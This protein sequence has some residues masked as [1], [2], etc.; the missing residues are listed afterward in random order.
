MAT[1]TC[2]LSCSIFASVKK[3][4]EIVVDI[5]L[6]SD[7]SN[8]NKNSSVRNGA[9]LA[10]KENSKKLKKN[11]IKIILNEYN[12]GK[13]VKKSLEVAREIT[14]SNSKAVIG[15]IWSSDALLASPIYNRNKIPLMVPGATADRLS[16]FNGYIHL[17]CNNNNKMAEKLAKFVKSKINPHKILSVVSQ[18]CAYCKNLNKVFQ[19]KLVGKINYKIFKILEGSIREKD[20]S[21]MIKTFKP[22]TIFL[23]NKARISAQLMKIAYEINPKISFVGADSWGVNPKVLNTILGDRPIIGYSFSQWHP[24]IKQKRSMKFQQL[25]VKT[26]GI[27][28]DDVAALTYDATQ[29]LIKAILNLTNI[30]RMEIER[31]L[32]KIKTFESISGKLKFELGSVLSDR[33]L[34]L[35]FDNVKRSIEVLE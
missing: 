32:N 15:H 25:Y 10:V 21:V 35:K 1:I 20:L 14:K 13:S 11:N 24:S 19:H 29:L 5:A 16:D 8:Y 12:Y 26:F 17:M 27:I 33:T 34:I 23:P 22:D 3:N 30:S 7:F 6:A 28:P 9:N 4:K 18:N 2:V 31:E